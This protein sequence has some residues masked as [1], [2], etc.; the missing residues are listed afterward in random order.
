MLGTDGDW[1]EVDQIVSKPLVRTQKALLYS[2]YKQRES[3]RS[4]SRSSALTQF[5]PEFLERKLHK[6]TMSLDRRL[7]TPRSQISSTASS[8]R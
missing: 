5:L 8:K 6:Y 2:L 7:T 1:T 3:P 4:L